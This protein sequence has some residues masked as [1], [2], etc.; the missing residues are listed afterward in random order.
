[1][2]LNKIGYDPV[3]DDSDSGYRRPPHDAACV[4]DYFHELA[5]VE[6]DGKFVVEEMEELLNNPTAFF[7][8]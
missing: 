7:G 6:D 1:M 8:G 2:P 5:G 3:D 4:C